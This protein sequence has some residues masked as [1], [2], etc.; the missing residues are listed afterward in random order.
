MALAAG[1]R[2]GPYE[3][4]APLGAGGMGEVYKGRDTRLD[5]Y[6]AIKILP[7]HLSNDDH[8]RER[9]EREARAVSA[10]NHPH[11][12][13]LHDIGHEDGLDFMVMEHIEGETLA[14]RLRTGGLPLEQA[15]AR[16]VEIAE[17]LHAAH[18]HGIVHRD[19]KPGNV[20]ITKVGAKLLDFGLA[21]RATAAHLAPES[22]LPTEAAPLT[23]EGAIVGTLHY[24]APEQ[25]EGREVDARADL[26][27][28]GCILYEMTSGARPFGGESQASLIGNILKDSP[29]SLSDVKSV[30]P[31]RLEW[32]VDRCLAK[33]P[34]QRWQSARDLTLE[35][36]EVRKELA[37]G[38]EPGT[39]VVQ[40][41]P[42]MAV[43]G[44]GVLAA[45][46]GAAAGWLLASRTDG[47]KAG[48]PEVQMRQ[49]TGLP[50]SNTVRSA[51]LSPDGESL[52]FV[53]E[54]GL[55]LQLVATGDERQIPLPE[56]LQ[57][58]EVDWL[59]TSSTL[60]FRAA[61]GDQVGLYRTSIF[62]GTPARL[63]GDAWRAAVSHD[64]QRVAYLDGLPSRVVHVM[65]ADGGKPRTLVQ[66]DGSTSFWDVAWSPDDR[67]LLAGKWGGSKTLN[68]TLVAIE[69][70]SGE[71]HEVL[72]DPRFFQNWRAFLPFAWTPAGE[73]IVARR[74]LPPN[75][76]GSNLWK[77]PI[78]G[79]TARPQ[80]ALS[81]LTQLIGVNFKDLAVS[82]AGV[83]SFLLE[84]NQQDVMLADID[85]DGGLGDVRLLV[86][87][88]RD[89]WPL[90]WSPHHGTLFFG[91]RR[92]GAGE[93]YRVEVAGG[94]A[95]RVVDRGLSAPNYVVVAADGR[96]LLFWGNPS[97]LQ[98]VPLDGG[99][100]VDVLEAGEWPGHRC[101][102]DRSTC[103]LGERSPDGR[104]Y[105]LFS[106]DWE[107]GRGEPVLR[108]AN[109]S[110][111]TEWDL[112]P[113]GFRVAV[114][115]NDDRL[116]VFEL[117]T[118]LETVIEVPGWHY[119]EFPRW[120]ADSQGVYIDGGP[121]TQGQRKG[122]LHISLDGEV[123]SLRQ[124][125][126]E[127]VTFPVPS[128][129]GKHLAFASQVF[130]ADVWVLENP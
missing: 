118:G 36:G 90:G 33:D 120:A 123:R 10:L 66:S 70:A 38:S 49:L 71:S 50:A 48:V 62:G 54:A 21:L 46:F 125:W 29:P 47:T 28:L 15:M 64:G 79:A 41:V 87:D 75:Q 61:A 5:R 115:G 12:C 32:L 59:G 100:V 88:E 78:D 4:L 58:H 24:M 76:S 23:A 97:Q 9:F 18:T 55:F 117:A 37:V 22:H 35:L 94:R 106:L 113:D 99:P 130:S 69:V 11:I 25:L 91:T 26:W 43:L 93:L 110:S 107:D 102:A 3:I 127:W 109:E 111:F 92:A 30:T 40:S 74:E 104:S 114:S 95:E 121:A 60:L 82:N 65:D 126:N 98:R 52:A 101:S 84:R 108:F 73:L 112:S 116:R 86:A 42:W 124:N 19:L 6:V 7:A 34:D 77:V 80:G 53:T 103:L 45:L 1:T 51:A 14:E 20:M 17:A 2:L 128:P 27:A 122:L 81:R 67:W 68:N 56:E 63:A 85:A 119:G 39:V 96:S 72:K 44:A 129:D 8:R 89:D 57:I 105:T 13:V 83:L 16:A 31:R